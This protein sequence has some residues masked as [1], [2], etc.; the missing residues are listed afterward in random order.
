MTTWDRIPLKNPEGPR[1]TT[2]EVAGHLEGD[3]ITIKA[4]TN[5]GV[6]I[7]GLVTRLPPSK[8]STIEG[9]MKTWSEYK[10]DVGLLSNRNMLYRGQ[11]KNWCISH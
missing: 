8:L 6:V 2:V 7:E 11:E 5:L 9:R 3:N 1:S 4:R 10:T